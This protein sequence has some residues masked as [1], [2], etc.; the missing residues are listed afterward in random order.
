MKK[1][2]LQQVL[3][4]NKHKPW[5]TDVKQDECRD[6]VEFTINS[7][8]ITG[9]FIISCADTL[10]NFSVIMDLLD[11][12]AKHGGIKMDANELV[13]FM[14]VLA[15]LGVKSISQEDIPAL[16]LAGIIIKGLRG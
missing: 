9:S 6:E 15:Q 4:N 7:K 16:L 2:R 11:S 12:T 10:E 13:K 3:E 14:E 1:T 8:G 5:L